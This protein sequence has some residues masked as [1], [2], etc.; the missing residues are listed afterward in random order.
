M[1]KLRLP[2]YHTLMAEQ[3]SR[4]RYL[5]IGFVFASSI[6][7]LPHAYNILSGKAELNSYIILGSNVVIFLGL[8]GWHL[9]K[10]NRINHTF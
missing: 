9:Y 3:K 10:L 7:A 1:S 2:Q 4:F 6:S 5:C 8:V